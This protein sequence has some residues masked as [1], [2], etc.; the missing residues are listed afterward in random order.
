MDITVH[1]ETGKVLSY[2]FPV[3]TKSIERE[4]VV[5]V[6]ARWFCESPTV[7]ELERGLNKWLKTGIFSQVI[8][9]GWHQ[10]KIPW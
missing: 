2:A 4:P 1:C 10:P 6:D 8:T 3:V 7:L 9:M 5:A